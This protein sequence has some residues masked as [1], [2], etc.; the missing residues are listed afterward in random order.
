M[1]MNTHFCLFACLQI[2]SLRL[3]PEQSW[4]NPGSEL[5]STTLRVRVPG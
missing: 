4:K 3:D 5:G 2:L 1:F